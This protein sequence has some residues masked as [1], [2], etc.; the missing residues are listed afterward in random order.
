MGGGEQLTLD[1][2]R[3]EGEATWAVKDREEIPTLGP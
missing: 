2:A 3:G 1:V